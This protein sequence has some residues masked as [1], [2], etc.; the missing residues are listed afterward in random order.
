MCLTVQ[1]KR[2]EL[3]WYCY[4]TDLNRTRL[5]IPPF[6]H[7][8]TVAFENHALSTKNMLSQRIE[9]CKLFLRKMRNFLIFL[10][11]VKKNVP[12]HILAPRRGC[13]SNHL[14]LRRV[15]ILAERFSFIGRIFLWKKKS[16]P[17]CDV[18]YRA[19]KE[20]WTLMILLSY[21][22]E[23]YASANSA[24]PAFIDCGFWKPCA[25][26]KKYVIT[27]NRR[28]QAFFEKNEKFFDIPIYCK[29]ECALAHSRAEA[30]LL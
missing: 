17:Q 12:W 14:P 16:T 20:T 30:R 23:P 2:L 5:P 3:S 6:L 22:P 10:F 11:T 4:H 13:F 28:V 25:V 9:E 7:L 21:G 19:G 27:E 24:I 1:E 29:K 15:R 18:P 26:N 8:L